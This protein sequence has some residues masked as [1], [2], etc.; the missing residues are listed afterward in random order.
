MFRTKRARERARSFIW[1]WSEPC[2]VFRSCG[3]EASALIPTGRAAHGVIRTPVVCSSPVVES[4]APPR[5][6]LSVLF[7][8]PSPCSF[9]LMVGTKNI[10]FLYCLLFRPYWMRATLLFHTIFHMFVCKHCLNATLSSSAFRKGNQNKTFSFLFFF[11]K[12]RQTW[13]VCF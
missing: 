13:L 12:A 8:D 2:H 4:I 6:G 9:L 5:H 11:L 1:L 3:G 7:P 10:S